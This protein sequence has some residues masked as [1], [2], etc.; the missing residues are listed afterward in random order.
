MQ[1]AGAR[2]A[3]KGVDEQSTDAFSFDGSESNR[4]SAGHFNRLNFLV[5]LVGITGQVY[6]FSCAGSAAERYTK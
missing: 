6:S 3:D 4:V 5:I 2:V 1:P